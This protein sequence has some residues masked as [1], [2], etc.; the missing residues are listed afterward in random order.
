M[1]R[2]CLNKKREGE[3]YCTVHKT[4]PPY[5]SVFDV[6]PQEVTAAT[7]YVAKHGMR[8]THTGDG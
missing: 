1:G 2:R 4:N 5:R 3:N 7:E 6:T 8:S